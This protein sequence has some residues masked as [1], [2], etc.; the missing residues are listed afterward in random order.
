MAG[1]ERPSRP[2]GP[3]TLG[4]D[5]FPTRAGDRGTPSD[6]P[7]AKRRNIL[8]RLRRVLFVLA[9]AGLAS[10]VGLAAVIANVELPEPEELLQSSF[11]C[12]VDVAPGECD[13]DT[14]LA[15]LS[16]EEDRNNVRLEDVPDHL[17]EAVIATEDRQFFEHTGINPVAI[18]RALY[19]DIRGQGVQQGGSTIT[20]QFAKNKYLTHDRTLTR[21]LEEAALSIK[22]EQQM[23]KEEILEGYLN[24]I[25]FG[26]NAY[27][28]QSATRAYFDKDVQD[29]ALWEAAFLAGLI[30]AP[31]LAEPEKY[32]EEATRRRATVL[33]AMVAE[34]YITEDERELANAVEWTPGETIVPLESHRLVDVRQGKAIGAEYVTAYVQRILQEELGFDESEIG[35]GG[36][37]VYTTLDMRLQFAAYETIYNAETGILNQEGDPSAALVALDNNGHIK[38]MVGG[39]NFEENQINL[40]VSGSGSPG[41]AVGSTFK[42]VALALAAHEGYSLERSGFNSPG[43]VELD[44]TEAAPNCDPTWELRN[45][46]ESEQGYMNL[47]NA[48]RV[49]SNTAYAQL[50]LELR[51]EPVAAMAEE[52]GMDSPV[53]PCP[54]MVLGPD[55]SNPLEMGEVYSTFAN[56]GVHKEPTIITRV[57]QV[58]QDGNV[59]LVW[60]WQPEES[61]VMSEEATDLV[62]HALRTVI[63]GGTG[64]AADIGQPAAGKTGTTQD[65]K[66]AW[67]VGYVPRLTTAVWMGYPGEPATNPD[68]G[69]VLLDENGDPI[70]GDVP[71]MDNVHGRSVT[72]GSFP[73][74]IWGAFMRLAT[75][76]LELDDDFVEPSPEA[77]RDGETLGEPP[78]TTTAPTTVP[79]TTII[80]IPVEPRPQ[81]PTTTEN[82]SGPPRGPT[83]TDSPDPTDDDGGGNGGDG[84]GFFPPGN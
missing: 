32:P 36:L 31:A 51:P 11:I 48:T 25:Y 68:T 40:A 9:L 21:K 84:G 42:P 10:F 23:S 24:T 69:E 16:G 43:T 28:V 5:V 7:P 26:R 41:R 3:Q 70:I 67:F 56:R 45:Y 46:A 79:E 52:L 8:W 37:R 81:R 33:E 61:R 65:N 30:R 29:L 2:R 58:D 18:G 44:Q 12:P 20:Q 6:I 74:E 64:T 49:S 73:A 13:D 47:I 22:V 75:D 35:G 82:G 50:M 77:L 15:K 78:T 83:T 55:N 59:D 34:G 38:A 53:T 76:I 54:P 57:E 1:S 66:D 4:T 14:A 60:E 17:I 71:V 80:T 62:T 72:G 39:R 63:Q 27:G 19:Q